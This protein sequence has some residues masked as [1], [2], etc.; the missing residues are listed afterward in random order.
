MMVDIQTQGQSILL[1][2]KKLLLEKNSQKKKKNFMQEQ[3]RAKSQH[4]ERLTY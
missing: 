1:I 3:S 2:R 4:N